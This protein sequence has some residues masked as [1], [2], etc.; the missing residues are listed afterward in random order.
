MKSLLLFAILLFSINTFASSGYS[1]EHLDGTATLDVEF[2]NESQAGVSEVSD[3]VGWAVT[4]SYEK[5]VIPTKPYA[6]ITRFELDNGA[7]LK[8]FDIDTSSL[9][10]LV[11]PNG[12]TYFYS[13]ES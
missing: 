4:A 5:M 9:G 7:T 13:C 3:D 10:I 2:I 1:C 11:Y 8:V 6:V 12:P